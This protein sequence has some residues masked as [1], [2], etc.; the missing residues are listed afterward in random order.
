[1]PCYITKDISQILSYAKK[2]SFPGD[3]FRYWI[4]CKRNSVYITQTKIRDEFE[5][6]IQT[7]RIFQLNKIYWVFIKHWAWFNQAQYP[8]NIIYLGVYGGWNFPNENYQHNYIDGTMF[9]INAWI[10]LFSVMDPC[11]L[12]GNC[13]WLFFMIWGHDWRFKAKLDHSHLVHL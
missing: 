1:M 4:G 7:Y 6:S 2:W 8:P 3:N 9:L 12:T 5:F 13:R 11:D 10:Q